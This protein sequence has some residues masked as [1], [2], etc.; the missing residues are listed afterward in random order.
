G[1]ELARR[2]ADQVPGEPSLRVLPHRTGAGRRLAAA[3]P[4]HRDAHGPE[5]RSCRVRG[6]GRRQGPYC[7]R[8]CLRGA[9][10]ADRPVGLA[11]S[12][13]AARLPGHLLEQVAQMKLGLI[14]M[15]GVRVQDAELMRLGLSLPGF[16]ERSR[17]IASLPS[18]ALLTLA[19]QVPSA[20]DV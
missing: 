20:I 16:V 13:P 9:T 2:A 12:V 4:D 15:S 6:H 1:R 19:G 10:P 18:L 3:G 7:E 11:V 17:V 5:P 14:A 8:Q